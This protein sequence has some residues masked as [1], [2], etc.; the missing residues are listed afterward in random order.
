VVA[1]YALFGTPIMALM[2]YSVLDWLGERRDQ[3]GK[4]RLW[5]AIG[6]G[7]AG[8]VVGQLVE[9][10]GLRASFYGYMALMF[11][12][13]LVSW[14][15]PISKASIGRGLLGGLR[16][17]FGRREWLFFLGIVFIAG[18][19]SSTVHNYLFL[20]MDELGA[21]SLTMGLA[22]TCATLGELAVFG[23]SDRLLKRVGTQ[24]MLALALF[25]HALRVLAYSVIRVPWLVLPVQLLHGL[26][27]SALWV[28]C[29]SQANRLAPPG[30][31]ATAQGLFNSVLFGLGGSLGA[32]AG[33]WLYEVAGFS[34]MFRLAAG[35]AV[36]GLLL[37]LTVGRRPGMWDP[38]DN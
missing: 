26:A 27:F 19:S 36:L 13:L 5:G 31:G 38:V 37:L 34:P 28:A 2:D 12:G 22:L 16:L 33:G 24:H 15:M 4:L 21:S 8:P 18:S 14:S 10:W 17:L 25:A 29:V 6:W 32:L 11:A 23:V 30:M 3:Y 9:L 20:Y 1:L 7:I 35:W